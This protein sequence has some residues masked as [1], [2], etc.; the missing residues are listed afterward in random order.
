[1]KM[2]SFA[3]DQ[4]WKKDGE[5]IFLP[6]FTIS[7]FQS[8]QGRSYSMTIDRVT[9]IDAGTYSCILAY[10]HLLVQMK[11]LEARLE[12]MKIIF[13]KLRV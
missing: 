3:E 5:D 12:L 11:K 7:E 2:E 4:F 9:Y 10:N 1:M 13:D 8:K 6:R